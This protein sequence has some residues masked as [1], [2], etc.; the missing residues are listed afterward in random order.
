M[1]APQFP[2]G[3]GQGPAPVAPQPQPPV[4]PG[5]PAPQYAP[6]APAQYPPGTYPPAAYLPAPQYAQP[7]YGAPQVYGPPPEQPQ[8]TPAG[9]TLDG[10]LAQ[11]SAGAA[12]WKFPQEGHVNI[13]M[14]ARD[15]RDTDVAQVTFKGQPIRRQDG[16][17]SQ[18]KALTIPLVNADGSESV[19]EVKGKNRDRLTAAVQ[20]MG[21]ASGIP[22]GG[23]MLRVQFTRKEQVPGSSAVAHVL[24]VQYA[25]P[26][27]AGQVQAGTAPAASVAQPPTP[28]P[29]QP[30]A[31]APVPQPQAPV[32]P[33]AQTTPSP[34][35]APVPAPVAAPGL[36]PEAAAQFQNMLGGAQQ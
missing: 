2:A 13:G 5:P 8:F 12:Y 7:Q 6:P 30:V 14:V 29:M 9:G 27:G 10:Y 31:Q 21:V 3:W 23:G 36:S 18:E 28:I 35:A 20:A 26:Q 32:Q 15:L 25:R 1:T 24:D 4:F 22:E 17:I 34:T 11:R 19:W 16:S 33:V